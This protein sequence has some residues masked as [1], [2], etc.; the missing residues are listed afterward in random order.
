LYCPGGGKKSITDEKNVPET[1]DC[2]VS[3][4]DNKKRLCWNLQN[5][6]IIC[7]PE[8]GGRACNK[9]GECCHETCIGGCSNDNIKNCTVCKD[10]SYLD[11]SH[12]V[13]TVGCPNDTF[14]H[15]NRRCITKD[16]CRRI[17]KPLVVKDEEPTFPYI[18][19]NGV[20]TLDCP[21]DHFETEIDKMRSCK[22]CD[23]K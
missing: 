14:V 13:C 4:V 6:Q 11:I 17:K 5:C 21:A 7:P 18:P 2:P 16:E 19:F 20:C 22:K 9:L 10:Y 23:G 12:R 1:L 8:C 3:S 15:M